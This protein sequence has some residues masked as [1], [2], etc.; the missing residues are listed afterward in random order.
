LNK[1]VKRRA[2]VVGLFPNEGA[3][4]LQSSDKGIKIFKASSLPFGPHSLTARYS[5][6]IERAGSKSSI[7]V[8]TVTTQATTTALQS[9]PNP[10][11][12][13]Q[14]VTFTATVTPAIAGVPAGAVTFWDNGKVVQ[15][16]N[17]QGGT[18]VYR[19]DSLGPGRHPMTA[20]YGS[21]G[22]FA[23]SISPVLTQDVAKLPSTIELASEPD[24][25][26][27]GQDVK[28]TVTVSSTGG[29]PTGQVLF[30]DGERSIE[31]TVPVQSGLASVTLSN[32]SV[33]PHSITGVY[34]GDR[35]HAGATSPALNQVVLG[36]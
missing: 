8:Q 2:D 27:N 17:L 6:D 11:T 26:R 3:I 32:L 31:P 20:A 33:G 13:G 9:S 23:S 22:S 12:G 1:E 35:T 7:L 21:D 15:K 34:S 18:A 10:S 25:S 14:L 30:K 4:I 29:A 16:V 36:P 5:G 24:P 19:A 28:V